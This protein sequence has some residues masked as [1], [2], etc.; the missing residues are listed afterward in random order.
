MSPSDNGSRGYTQLHAQRYIQFLGCWTF[1]NPTDAV[2]RRDKH[3][4]IQLLLKVVESNMTRADKA[5][6]WETI[7][8]LEALD[9]LL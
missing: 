4:Y 1:A 5:G 6:A 2:K 7:A 9:N 8:A 3:E